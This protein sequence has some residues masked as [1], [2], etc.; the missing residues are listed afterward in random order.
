MFI[1]AYSNIFV[2]KDKAS[3]FSVHAESVSRTCYV[4]ALIGYQWN[5]FYRVIPEIPELIR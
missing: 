3:Y 1:V 5:N 2:Y 4:I